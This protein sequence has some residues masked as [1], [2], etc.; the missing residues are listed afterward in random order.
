VAVCLLGAFASDS[1][2][3][4]VVASVGV[5][6]FFGLGGRLSIPRPEGYEQWEDPWVQL[7]F[8][9]LLGAI[10]I[11]IALA[12]GPLPLDEAKEWPQ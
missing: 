9:M 6:G 1:T 12:A 4:I 10:L 2:K 3:H 5:I 8:I 7:F 11:G